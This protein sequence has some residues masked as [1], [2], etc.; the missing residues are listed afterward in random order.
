VSSRIAKGYTKKPCLEKWNPITVIN[1][2]ISEY[3]NVKVKLAKSGDGSASKSFAF[4]ARGPKPDSHAEKRR[5]G[6]K[7][8]GLRVF[9]T[10]S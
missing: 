3:L 10:K 9:A 7:V 8:Q 6:E 4:Y 2:H 1:V 5:I